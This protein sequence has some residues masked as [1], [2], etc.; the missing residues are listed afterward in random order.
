M[1]APTRS[2]DPFRDGLHRRVEPDPRVAREQLEVEP[3]E[4]SVQI[5]DDECSEG[6]ANGMPKG[7]FAAM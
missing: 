2:L 6:A 5:G 4:G 1:C 3:R 7:L